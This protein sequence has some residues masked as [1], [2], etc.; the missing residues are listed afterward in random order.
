[1]SGGQWITS[2]MSITII[3]AVAQELGLVDELGDLLGRA[4]HR[5]TTSTLFVRTPR[6]SASYFC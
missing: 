2:N 1:M 5:S 4:R 6:N 3:D